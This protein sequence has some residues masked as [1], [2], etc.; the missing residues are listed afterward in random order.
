MPQDPAA[1]RTSVPPWRI[2]IAGGGI[3]GLAL[4]LAVT[5]A[6][7]AAV[8]VVLCDPAL[9]RDPGAD[10]RA[11]AVAA[12]A[13]RM[14]AVLGV[15]PHLAGAVQPILDMVVTDSRLQDP[16]RPVFLTFAGEVE[17]GEPFAHMVEGGALSGALLAGCEAAGVSLRHTAV[18]GVA[19]EPQA[20]EAELDDGARLR[21][22]LVVAADGGR[23]RL[24]EDAGIGWVAWDYPQS[25]IVATVA[26]ARDHEGRAVEHF[27]PAGPFA[28]LP[29][30][31]GG[32]LGHRTSIV[33]TERDENVAALLAL[34]PEDALI[35]VERRFGLHLGEIGL[36]TP[37]QAFPLSFGLTR[38]FAAERLA[39]LGDAAHLIHPLAGQGLNLALRDAAALAEGIVDTVRL[40]L[41]PGEAGVLDAYERA[42]RFDTFAMAAATDGLNRLFSNDALPVR[43]MRDLG[44]G[45]VDRMDGLKRG[46]MR[47]AA[48]PSDAGPRLMRGEML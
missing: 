40:G 12:D 16:V 23:S 27:L 6:L 8:E 9:K 3:A 22:A 35:E 34:P 41:D 44:L 17:P 42:R 33:W 43:L 7:G 4:A 26:H 37:L 36:E 19:H 14:L 15:W 2:A 30:A 11:Y 5:Q 38:R 47:Q 39:L 20:I 48:G 29:L 31:P 45:L 25:G 46:F 18:R 13:R 32:P 21:C 1:P 28:L 10:R 24:R